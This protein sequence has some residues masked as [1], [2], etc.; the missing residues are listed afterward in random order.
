MLP[1]LLSLFCCTLATPDYKAAL[2]SQQSLLTLFRAYAPPSSFSSHE[3]PLRVRIFRRELERVVEDNAEKSW[4]SGLNQFSLMTS[5]EKTHYLGMN[6]TS[7]PEPTQTFSTATDIPD[8]KD[9]RVEGKVTGV[10][11][12]GKCGSC[13]SFAAVG[14]IETAYAVTTGKLKQFSEQELLDCTYQETYDGC[15]G[16]WLTKPW[17]YTIAHQRLATQ[18]A[19]PYLGK[20]G[21]CAY[22]A[23]H[24]GLIAAKLASYPYV[25]RGVANV[26]Q[27]LLSGAV[28]AGFMVS[29]GF[30]RYSS[31]ILAD[32]TCVSDFK[33][34]HAVSIVG[35]TPTAVIVKNSWGVAWGEAGYFRWARDHSGCNLYSYCSGV[36][37]QS[38]G[39]VDGDQEYQEEEE[40]E[41]DDVTGEGC[42]CGTVRCEDGVCRHV[43]MC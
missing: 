20:D 43:H 24:D 4:D 33:G 15:R 32:D 38:T 22:S 34:H 7:V 26:I 39:L 29:N 19:A 5:E 13:W 28:G 30:Y 41:C 27:G 1:L 37:M 21:V 9:W 25:G 23:V 18:A 12:Q 6:M 3:L 36:V 40:E 14:P 42:E 31:G 35:Y 17:D 10:K 2:K 11:D 16:G 8:S